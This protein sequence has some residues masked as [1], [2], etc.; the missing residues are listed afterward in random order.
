MGQTEVRLPES[1]NSYAVLLTMTVIWVKQQGNDHSVE[2]WD[3][4]QNIALDWTKC[5]HHQR[6]PHSLKKKKGGGQR[7]ASRFK[8][9]KKEGCE[10]Q[11]QCTIFSP[12]DSGS[13]RT[14]KH[15]WRVLMEQPG[16]FEYGL[17]IRYYY[18]ISIKLLERNNGTEVMQENVLILRSRSNVPKDSR[19]K[20]HYAHNLLSRGSAKK[21]KKDMWVYMT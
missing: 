8:K 17:D 9:K 20:C 7:N 1:D 19:A 12:M 13:G 4:L 15:I 21:R 14:K 16:R 11:I 10:N 6:H 3:I 5:Q 18:W 2:L